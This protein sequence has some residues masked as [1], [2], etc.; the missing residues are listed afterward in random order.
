MDTHKKEESSGRE[1]VSLRV[2]N[3]LRGHSQTAQRS[4]RRVRYE[5]R[6]LTVWSV[7]YGSF[8]PR[9]RRTRRTSEEMAPLVDWHDSH[10]LAA[11]IVI[12]L[13]CFADAFLTINLVV[14]GAQEAN[15]LMAHL[16]TTD[17]TLF[18]AVKMGLTGTGVIVLVLL[19]RFRLFGRF[20]VAQGLYVVMIGYGLLVLYELA[21][22]AHMT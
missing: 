14:L 15:P 11:S 6:R 10:L 9:R 19:A 2:I 8:R 13:L 18:T 17:I 21:L 20:R 5:R 7:V 1:Q 4:E 12:L 16:M 22:L 3:Q